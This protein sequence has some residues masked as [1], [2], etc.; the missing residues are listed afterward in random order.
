MKRWILASVCLLML[1]GCATSS[2]IAQ[3]EGLQADV[4]L[5]PTLHYIPQ[6]TKN[7]ETGSVDDYIA[8]ANPYL[9]QKKRVNK[10][11]VDQY[12]KVKKAIAENKVKQAKEQLHI[13][14]EEHKKLSGPYV[15]LGNLSFNEGVLEV[16]I[17]HY[18]K[19]LE[20]NPLNVNAYLRLAK[21]FTENGQFLKA[22]N[23]YEEALSVWADFPEAHLN[24][25]V[26]YDLYLNHPINAE[27]HMATYQFLTGYKDDSVERWIAEI[28]KR[29][30]LNR[31]L[32]KLDK[33]FTSS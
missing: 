4:H 29:T 19:A 30:G 15:L 21:T 27:K 7:K 17:E 18:Q 13:M 12:L 23:T 31:T 6:R 8:S 10:T 3:Q 5:M 16:A 33:Q 32:P 1:G 9:Q 11:A 14:T 24:L 26:L 25:G 22:Q 2:N 20:I 28:R